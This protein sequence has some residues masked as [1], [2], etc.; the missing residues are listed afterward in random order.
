MRPC[1][2][3]KLEADRVV[4]LE[5]AEEPAVQIRLPQR[6]LDVGDEVSEHVLLLD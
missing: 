4:V 2:V 5:T 6:F 1:E 3:E